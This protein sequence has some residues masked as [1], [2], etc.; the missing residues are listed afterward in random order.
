MDNK[1]NTLILTLVAICLFFFGCK[2]GNW[3]EVVNDE[4]HVDLPEELQKDLK[5]VRYRY[6]ILKQY[7]EYFEE[8]PEPLQM[9]HSDF[10]KFCRENIPEYEENEEELLKR[11]KKKRPS[12][13]NRLE[14]K[15]G[16]SEKPQKGDIP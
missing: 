10:L 15:F 2:K 9:E 4:I 16:D 11:L 5:E 13:E 7:P 12:I 1:L 14:E 6:I 3:F 8:I